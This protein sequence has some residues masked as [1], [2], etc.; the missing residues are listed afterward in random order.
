MKYDL[1][2]NGKFIWK[3]KLLFVF[4]QS[5]KKNGRQRYCQKKWSIIE[6]IKLRGC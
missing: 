4:S 1:T 2:R 6:K 5:R 3:R